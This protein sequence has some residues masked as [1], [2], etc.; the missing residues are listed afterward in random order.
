MT[1]LVPGSGRVFHKKGSRHHREF[2]K[3]KGKLPLRGLHPSQLRRSAALANRLRSFTAGPNRGLQARNG[4]RTKFLLLDGFD[5]QGLDGQTVQ[6][7]VL[8]A[9]MNFGSTGGNGGTGRGGDG[10]ARRRRASCGHASCR[11]GNV[12][13]FKDL[14]WSD[15]ENTVRRFDEVVSLAATVLPS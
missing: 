1:G 2:E 8:P 15:A 12:D 13:I 9:A 7:S 11:H 3:W 4:R 10:D 5:L 6:G 14:A